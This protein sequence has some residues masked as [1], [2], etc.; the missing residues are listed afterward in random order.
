MPT[1]TLDRVRELARTAT[2]KLRTWFDPP[3]DATARPLE[4][5]EAIVA[6]IEALTEPVAAGR[7]V[8]TRSPIAV[9][10]LAEDKDARDLLQAA[11]A[12]L[13]AAVRTRLAEI[14]CP[15]PHGFAIDVHYVRKPRGG[16]TDGQRFAVEESKGAIKPAGTGA[17]SLRVT[18]LRGDATRRGYVFSEGKILVGRTPA[19]V[20]QAGRPRHNHVVFTDTGSEHNATVGRAHASIVF[21]QER[22][23]FRLFDD[24]SNN[25]TRIVR[26]GDILD[27]RPR[28]PV[29]IALLSGD[30]IQFGTAAVKIEIDA[31]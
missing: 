22:R 25:G 11:L 30:E 21:D 10:V 19:P 31:Q 5:R 7:R 23:Q 9:T 12:D 4:I 16:W 15:V 1:S 3:I 20:D 24:G 26:G 13:D 6:R 8:L 27:V 14:R 29:G 17:P 28:N 18:V 2:T